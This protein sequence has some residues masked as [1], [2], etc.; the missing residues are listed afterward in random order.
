MKNIVSAFLLTASF[1]T[2]NAQEKDPVL[3]TI[4]DKGV[5]LSEFNAIY[6]KNNSNEKATE[7][8]IKEYLN[9]MYKSKYSF[10]DCSVAFSLELFFL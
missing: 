1:L 9:L 10:I 5:N 4:G 2:I 7:Q 8:S 3:L 6:K